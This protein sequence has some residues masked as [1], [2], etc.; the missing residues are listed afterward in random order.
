MY[1]GNFPTMFADPDYFESK[2]ASWQVAK[3]F[4]VAVRF[5]SW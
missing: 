3:L 1:A 2:A 5:S 4:A